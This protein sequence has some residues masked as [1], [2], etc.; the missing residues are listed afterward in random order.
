[1]ELNVFY[2]LANV[3]ISYYAKE[4]LLESNSS[5]CKEA[6]SVL[7]VIGIYC[8]PEERIISYKDSEGLIH[9]VEYNEIENKT[10]HLN[11]I[12][13]VTPY[14][15]ER[16]DLECILEI[17]NRSDYADLTLYL[18]SLFDSIGYIL[19]R[20]PNGYSLRFVGSSTYDIWKE[21]PPS[22][23]E[24]SNKDWKNNLTDANGKKVELDKIN[25]M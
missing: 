22:L 16:F 10:N 17:I 25:W 18:T 23:I 8:K 5:I 14:E 24:E 13:K 21:F 15:F 19:V 4:G 2:N 1:M 12:S 9:N 7:R 6:E 20:L 3:Y 11:C